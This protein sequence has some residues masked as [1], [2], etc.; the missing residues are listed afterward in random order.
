MLV[1]PQTT[2]TNAARPLHSWRVARSVKQACTQDEAKDKV[3]RAH[4]QQLR[5]QV[6]QHELDRLQRLAAKRAEGRALK[7]Q[8]E[9]EHA[10]VEVRRCWLHDLLPLATWA[11]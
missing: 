1:A 4:A 5:Q 10:V 7:A 8:L 11:C 3:S 9:Q 6:T 2:T